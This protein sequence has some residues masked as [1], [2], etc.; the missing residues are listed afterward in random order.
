MNLLFLLQGESF[1]YYNEVEEIECYFPTNLINLLDELEDII[2]ERKKHKE[3]IITLKDGN[4]VFEDNEKYIK[5]RELE[6]K[7]FCDCMDYSKEFK[8]FSAR[9]ELLLSEM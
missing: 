1:I 8:V 2:K 3:F 7:L 6:G 5:L 4:F 9:S